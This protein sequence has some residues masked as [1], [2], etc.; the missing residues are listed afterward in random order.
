MAGFGV[1]KAELVELLAASDIVS[2]HAPLTGETY[3]LMDRDRLRSMKPGA[4]LVNTSRGQIVDETAL[5]TAL[6]EGWIAG[7]G[8]DVLEQEPP[9]PE[10]PLLAMPNIVLTPHCAF[11]SSE[12]YDD[13][14][15][16][17]AEQAIQMCRGEFPTHLVNAEVRGA[18][19]LRLRM[20]R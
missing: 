13:L 8:L 1:R 20:V 3:R 17:W 10:N 2:L 14:T 5:V 18:P 7:A 12:A 9:D 4:I 15:G 16:K 19:N 11:F 6:R